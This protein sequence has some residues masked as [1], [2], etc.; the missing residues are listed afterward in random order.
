MVGI[1]ANPSILLMISL[2]TPIGKDA[3]S[4]NTIAE[5][6]LYTKTLPMPGNRNFG[7]TASVSLF[8]PKMQSNSLLTNTASP[9][10]TNSVA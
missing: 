1:L 3:P 2:K 9:T 4:T 5:I 8:Y 6:K 10:T 7:T